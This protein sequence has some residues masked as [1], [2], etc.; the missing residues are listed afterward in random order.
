MN[1]FRTRAATLAAG[2]AAAVAVLLAVIGC[3]G[4]GG[5]EPAPPPA[6]PDLTAA[7]ADVRWLDYQG[8]RLPGGAA[9]ARPRS[10][11]AAAGLNPHPPPPARGAGRRTERLCQGRAARRRAT[12]GATAVPLRS[13]S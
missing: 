12:P 4:G 3:S 8:V 7:P 11:A 1:H 5:P 6:G 2:A 10:A 13:S 9:G